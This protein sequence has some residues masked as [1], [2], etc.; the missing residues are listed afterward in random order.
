MPYSRV[1]NDKKTDDSNRF[2]LLVYRTI[3]CSPA[4]VHLIHVCGFINGRHSSASAEF[5]VY[6]WIFWIL[7][8]VGSFSLSLLGATYIYILFW[9]SQYWLYI[10]RSDVSCFYIYFKRILL[11]CL[12][13]LGPTVKIKEELEVPTDHFN[14]SELVLKPE[15]PWTLEAGRLCISRAF[16]LLN[17]LTSAR[18]CQLFI[19]TQ[20]CIIMRLLSQTLVVYSQTFYTS[21]YIF[22][23][24]SYRYI[25]SD[26]I[27]CGYSHSC[28]FW[29]A[30]S[31]QCNTFVRCNQ[32]VFWMRPCDR[33]LIKGDML[34]P[35]YGKTHSMAL[36][37]SFSEWI[38]DA[39]FN[40]P[41]LLKHSQLVVELD[42]Y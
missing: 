38:G 3:K 18:T 30:S 6:L 25:L 22:F 27:K 28:F 29:I 7:A 14:S 24:F 31:F 26:F 33:Y 41:D 36:S 21:I 17:L 15:F 19:S 16:G 12:L 11:L 32:V 37:F 20:W 39:Q 8:P 42:N 34:Y 40:G 4:D 2:C 35:S 10:D 23:F 9:S 1:V 5:I 13:I